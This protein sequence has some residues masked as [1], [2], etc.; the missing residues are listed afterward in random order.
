MKDQIIINLIISILK[1]DR[2]AVISSVE[3]LDEMSEGQKRSISSLDACIRF[4]HK[5][6]NVKNK[7]GIIK[8]EIISWI[9]EE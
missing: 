1:R 8:N 3:N 4:M 9:K 5:V 6:Q 2:Q 7:L